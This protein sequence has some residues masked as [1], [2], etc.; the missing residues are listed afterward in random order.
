MSFGASVASG[1]ADAFG[2]LFERHART[3]YNHCFRRTGDWARS[4]DLTSVVFLECWRGRDRHVEPGKVLPW[5][6]GIATNVCRN[7]RRCIARHRAAFDRLPPPEPVFDL[8]DDSLDR[9]EDEHDMRALLSLLS[10]L[11]GGEQDVVALC[12]L[13]ELSYGDAAAALEIPIG[14]VRSRLARARAKLRTVAVSGAGLAREEPT[15]AVAGLATERVEN[16]ER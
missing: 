10:Q 1:D 5:L 3:I 6:L 13:A 8:S 16:D 4:E 15:R 7:E 12:V 2:L 9:L 11:A 14:T